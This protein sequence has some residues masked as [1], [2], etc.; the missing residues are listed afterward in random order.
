MSKVIVT[1][2]SSR[3]INLMWLPNIAKFDPRA[4]TK[5]TSVLGP[6]IQHAF[7]VRDIKAALRYW[8]NVMDV[9][10]LFISTKQPTKQRFIAMLMRYQST[11]LPSLIGVKTRLNWQHPLLLSPASTTIFF[12]TKAMMECFII[13]AWRSKTWR[14]SKAPLIWINSKYWPNWS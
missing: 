7:V 5:H 4:P 6:I 9:G 14:N 12:W 13:C 11:Q 2:L 8:I 3:L 1:A 10:P